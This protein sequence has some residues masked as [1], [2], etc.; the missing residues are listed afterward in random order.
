MPLPLAAL[1]IGSGLLSIGG[2]IIGGS[3]AA[4]EAE[5]AM[6]LLDSAMKRIE[7]LPIPQ[8][9]KEIIYQQ[10]QVVGDFT[11][12]ALD[13]TIEEYAPLALIQEDPIHKLRQEATYSKIA[14]MA[15]TGYTP[16]QKLS[17]EQAKREAARSAL[18]QMASIESTAKRQGQL[19]GGQQLALKAQAVQ[20][21]ADRQAQENL[22]AAA[23]GGQQQIGAL[24]RMAGLE[25]Y[26]EQT[27]LG[28]EEKNVAARNLRDELAMKYST[29][30]QLQNKSWAMEEQR[31]R[32]QAEQE[33]SRANVQTSQAEALRRGYTAPLE[34]A[35][36]RQ[37][38]E[39]AIANLMGQKAGAHMG[40]GQSKAQM[41]SQIGSGA[42]SALMGYGGLQAAA[43]RTDV[44]RGLTKEGASALAE[45][46]AFGE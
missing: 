42:G 15:Q 19:T 10:F 40:L 6:A 41:W 4:D 3:K 9:D 46:G 2:G 24:E 20:S 33:A 32:R 23:T 28:T 43:D 35:R 38:K 12:Q 26:R 45:M 31:A 44:L 8:L 16:Q 11:P 39:T 18:S 22:A 7:A 36:L 25:Q 1:A 13:K 21:A 29:A 34:M 30:R 14:Q 37:Q 27:A 5:K 17:M